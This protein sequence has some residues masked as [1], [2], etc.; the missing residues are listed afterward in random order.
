MPIA[1]HSV[2]PTSAP[3][4]R[5]RN[6]RGRFRF[7][8]ARPRRPGNTFSAD[9]IDKLVGLAPHEFGNLSQCKRAQSRKYRIELRHTG[10]ILLGLATQR[11]EVDDDGAQL[12]QLKV[13]TRSLQ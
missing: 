1:L 4:C 10:W 9:H 2:P 11:L 7:H 5:N 6:V 12:R 8:P 13:V 3:S